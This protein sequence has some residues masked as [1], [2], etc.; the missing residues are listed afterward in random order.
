MLGNELII[1]RCVVAEDAFAGRDPL[2]HGLGAMHGVWLW[3]AG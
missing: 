2:P 1:T 3:D